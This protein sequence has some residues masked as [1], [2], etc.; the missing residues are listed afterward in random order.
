M[1]YALLL[2]GG[3]ALGAVQIPIIRHLYEKHG[4][5]KRIAGVSVGAVNGGLLGED[6][7]PDL[8]NQWAEVDSVRFF[9]SPQLDFWKGLISLNPLRK[10]MES[11]RFAENLKTVVSV[12]CVDIAAQKYV[13]VPLN[14]IGTSDR[15][16]A[17]ICSAA[18]PLIMEPEKF[19]GRF[20]VDGGVLHVLPNVQEKELQDIDE[21]HVISCSPVGGGRRRIRP[22]QE[23]NSAFEQAQSSFEMLM[24]TTVQA[25]VERLKKHKKPVYLYFPATWGEVGRSFDASKEAVQLRMGTGEKLK[26]CPVR[27]N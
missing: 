27:I 15:V 1:N 16:D 8:L 6:R 3:T 26:L 4:L 19:L 17:A 12:G 22:P 20:M 18:Q 25:D 9:G 7:L 23:V 2:G 10:R 14:Q 24:S 21:I 5:P 13:D 11:L